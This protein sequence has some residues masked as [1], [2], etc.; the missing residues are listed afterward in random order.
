MSIKRAVELLDEATE[1]GRNGFYLNAVVKAQTAMEMARG[2]RGVTRD[3]VWESAGALVE[4]SVKDGL[5][6][7]IGADGKNS[8]RTIRR[9]V[10]RM[11]KEGIDGKIV[12]HA[13]VGR[14]SNR[15]KNKQPAKTD[16]ITFRCSPEQKAKWIKIAEKHYDGSLTH[17]I[18]D[19]IAKLYSAKGSGIRSG[20]EK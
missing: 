4:N 19:A 3:S 6:S 13:L 7:D 17:L 16:Q 15:W 20:N 2:G 9:E 12:V 18:E 11:V 5:A 14:P 10:R 1:D 8:L